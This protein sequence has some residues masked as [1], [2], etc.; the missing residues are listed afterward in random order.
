MVRKI[1]NLKV[2]KSTDE[3]LGEIYFLIKNS[4]KLKQYAQKTN[5]RESLLIASQ[6]YKKAKE[7]SKEL[8]DRTQ[9]KDNEIDY[10]YFFYEEKKALVNFYALDKNYEKSIEVL[11]EMEV[12]LN[13]LIK[14]I[15]EIDPKNE[16]AYCQSM[17][18]ECYSVMDSDLALKFRYKGE[19]CINDGELSKAL[20][21]ID[22]AIEKT[23]NLIK[24]LKNS[25]L[26]EKIEAVHLQIEESNLLAL[27][28]RHS[29]ILSIIHHKDSI[30]IES[31][32]ECL[33]A[34]MNYMNSMKKNPEYY[35]VKKN[36]NFTKDRLN[37]ILEENMS[38]KKWEG[39]YEIFK[40]D[41]NLVIQMKE[42]N[43]ELFDKIINTREKKVIINN[44]NGILSNYG[45]IGSDNKIT[46]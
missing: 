10:N 35:D 45:N 30:E 24:K 6:N 44:Q 32:K 39:F 26:E 23:E 43:N 3:I 19:K 17:L 5:S 16:I 7:L 41:S 25:V 42:L 15:N 46:K 38:Y 37:L 11:E 40:G 12:L 36:Y 20:S 14:K 2:S 34:I 18:I 9:N 21:F 31:L 22:L 28:G 29:D 1:R 4:E 13:N 27:K 33:D 8:F